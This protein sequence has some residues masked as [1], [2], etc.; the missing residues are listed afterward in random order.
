VEFPAQV[1]ERQAKTLYEIV[2]RVRTRTYHDIVRTFCSCPNGKV[3][4]ETY[5]G[6]VCVNGHS[7]SNHS[8][9]FSMKLD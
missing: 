2:Y 5:D 7:D 9:H 3:T 1:M 4:T 6:Y 8:L